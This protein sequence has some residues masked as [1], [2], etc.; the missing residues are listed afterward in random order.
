MKIPYPITYCDWVALAW[1]VGI[2][3]QVNIEMND[4]ILHCDE[5]VSIS[6]INSFL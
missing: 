1:R 6:N 2:G 5:M 4:V 3:E